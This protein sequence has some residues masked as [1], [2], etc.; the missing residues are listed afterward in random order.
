MKIVGLVSPSHQLVL[1]IPSSAA[2]SSLTTTNLSLSSWWYRLTEAARSGRHR[3]VYAEPVDVKLY[4]LSRVRLSRADGLSFLGH[5]NKPGEIES[6]KRKTRKK[7]KE[8]QVVY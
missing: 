1:K 3:T 4:F 7:T 8:E 5:E 6:R 2:R